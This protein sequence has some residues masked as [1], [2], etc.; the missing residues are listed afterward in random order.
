MAGKNTIRK[1]KKKHTHTSNCSHEAQTD[2]E[3]GN[4]KHKV[5]Q[6][7]QT[8]RGKVGETY[9]GDRYRINREEKE[10]GK[11]GKKEEQPDNTGKK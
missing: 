6:L 5:D 9:W 8:R 11:R 3:K 2:W 10:N 7:L 4:R 1:L